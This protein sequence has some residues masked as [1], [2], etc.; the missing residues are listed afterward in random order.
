MPLLILFLKKIALV[1]LVALLLILS[2]NQLVV[3]KTAPHITYLPKENSQPLPPKPMA[4][5]FGASVRGQQLSPA[6]QARMDVALGLYHT[7]TVQTL[8]LSGDGEDP[9]YSETLAMKKFALAHGVP[10]EDILLDHKGKS[11][12]QTLLRAKNIFYACDLY[13]VSQQFHLPRV[14]LIAQSLGMNVTG[15]SAGGIQ[16]SWYYDLR[17]MPARAKDMGQIF[18]PFF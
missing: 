13:V 5:V 16:N 2:I 12:R 9:Y 11:T 3:L 14:V 18:F 1:V 7:G 17:E 8:L 4:L 10:E 15:V 6:L